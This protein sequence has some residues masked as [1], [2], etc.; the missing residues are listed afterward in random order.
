[1]VVARHRRLNRIRTDIA[2][3]PANNNA[4]GDVAYIRVAPGDREA[5][6]QRARDLLAN[7]LSWHVAGTQTRELY[8]THRLIARKAGFADLLLAF[9]IAAPSLMTSSPMAL[10]GGSRFS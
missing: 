6:L 8:L 7:T 1:M 9:R 5:G 3:I 2:R 4:Q 10:T